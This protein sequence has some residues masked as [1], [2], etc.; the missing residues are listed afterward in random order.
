MTSVVSSDP[1]R[2]ETSVCRAV[3]FAASS[4]PGRNPIDLAELKL[5]PFA[6]LF[7]ASMPSLLNK[8]DRVDKLNVEQSANFL[9]MGAGCPRKN[10]AA[11]VAAWTL[12]YA[13]AWI[14]SMRFASRTTPG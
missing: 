12:L 10:K 6:P 14:A 9:A 5:G 3:I 13:N 8:V 7:A 11:T 1:P 4:G 2:A